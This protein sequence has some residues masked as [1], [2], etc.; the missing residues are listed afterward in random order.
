MIRN[1]R[2]L[3]ALVY[4]REQGRH[5]F[6]KAEKDDVEAFLACDRA[7]DQLV[8]SACRNPFT[9]RA[10]AQLHGHSRRFWHAYRDEDDLGASADHH[11]GLTREIAEGGA[12]AAGAASDRL[13]DY[14]DGFA[15]A[16][17]GRG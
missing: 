2:Y 6:L 11:A 5:A 7:F 12:K 4:M 10:A 17:L 15:Q 9:A 8:A 13:I 14:L 1:E 16:A 3:V